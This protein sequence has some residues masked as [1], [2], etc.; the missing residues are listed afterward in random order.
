MTNNNNTNIARQA[1]KGSLYSVSSSATTIV[2]GFVRTTVLLRLL[3]P[4]HYGV[5]TL[6]LLYVNLVSVLCRFGFDQA[7]IHHKAVTES[8]RRTYFAMRMGTTLIGLISLVLLALII[9][10]FY[11]HEPLLTAVIMAYILVYA[12][13]EFNSSQVIILRKKLA[14][15]HISIIDVISSISMTIVAPTLAWFGW[16][17]GLL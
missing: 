6:A 10:R 15:R 3:S 12:I 17:F 1:T 16:G 5:T 14:F 8:V 7:L 2:L 9:G 13:R 11:P 4:T